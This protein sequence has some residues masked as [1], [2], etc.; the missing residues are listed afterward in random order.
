MEFS[1]RSKVVAQVTK[2]PVQGYYEYDGPH[3]HHFCRKAT[4]SS[5]EIP[6]WVL[7]NVPLKAAVFEGR[8]FGVA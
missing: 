1:G 8:A 5:V 3:P 2:T 7:K 4:E 6:Y